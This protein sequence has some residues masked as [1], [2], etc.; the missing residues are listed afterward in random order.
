[1]ILREEYLNKL[2]KL[3]DTKI[4]KVITGIRRCGKSTLLEMFREYLLQNGVQKEQITAINFEDMDYIE[5]TDYKRLYSYLKERLVPNKMNYIFLDEIQ[6]VESYQKAVDSLYIK[7][8]VD[9]YI[10]GSNAHMLSGE[11][12]TLLS[13]RYIEM[14]MLPLSFKEYLDFVGDRTDLSRKYSDYL[15]FSSFPYAVS[16]KNDRSLIRDY[17]SGIYNTV[18]LKD[19]VAR[20]K[21]S[22]VMLLESVIR[23]LFDNIGNRWSTKKIS[24]TMTSD[25]RKISTHTVDSYLSA[26]IDSYI[27]YH[28][29]RYD[30][31]GKQILK[32]QEKYYIVDIGLRYYLL[33]NK[34]VDIGHI[35]E[36]VVY[37]ELLRRGYEVS[38]GKVDDMEV[39]FIASNNDGI[40]YYQVAA[41]VRDVDTLD[42]ELKPLKKIADHFPK[43]LLTLDDDPPTSHNGIRQINA[44]NFLL[45]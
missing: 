35:L 22:D 39:D 15:Q 33:G 4:I 24:D 41:T 7:E 10:T 28:A 45:N 9:L 2:I 18:L 21:I 38:I 44:L 42:R 20:K 25:G 17:L 12:A 27:I 14:Q 1:M 16:L 34:G 32:T 13:G 40:E 30:V 43:Y 5:L 23:F 29:K 6:L 11:L 3:K 31:K 37:L 8:N 36:N 19:V 26:L